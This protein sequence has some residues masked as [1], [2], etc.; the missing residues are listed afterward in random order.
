MKIGSH[1]PAAHHDRGPWVA[2]FGG[3]ATSHLEVHG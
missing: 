2:W 1:G 3:I